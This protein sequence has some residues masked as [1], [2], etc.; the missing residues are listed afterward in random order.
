MTDE[1]E[2][3]GKE[4]IEAYSRYYTD[5]YLEEVCN[6]KKILNQDSRCL[7]GDSNRLTTE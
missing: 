7:G 6:N 1:L 5:I 2:G 4:V 3:I